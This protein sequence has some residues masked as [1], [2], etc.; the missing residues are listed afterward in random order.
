MKT[1]GRECAEI[2]A[3]ASGLFLKSIYCCSTKQ[4]LHNPSPQRLKVAVIY[5]ALFLFHSGREKKKKE[6]NFVSFNLPVDYSL[7]KI[8]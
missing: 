2:C 6:I 8:I 5:S 3:K 1:C 4:Q 7:L